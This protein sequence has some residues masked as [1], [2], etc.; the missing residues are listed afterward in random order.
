M[1]KLKLLLLAFMATLGLSVNAAVYVIDETFT[2]LDGLDETL[3][4]IVNESEGKA[5]CFPT[6]QDMAY[7]S[8]ADAVNANSYYFKLEPAQGEGVEGYYYLR[9]YYAYGSVYAVWSNPNN[10]YFN[11]QPATGSV[12]FTIGKT[13][14]TNGQDIVNGAVWALEKSGDKFAIKNIGTGKYLKD[15]GNANQDEPTFFSF[16]TYQEVAE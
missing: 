5:F 1:R 12:C 9:T 15:A 4:S 8:Y 3:F 6:N 2:S 7:Q 13:A 16:Y 14:K 10:G 11:S